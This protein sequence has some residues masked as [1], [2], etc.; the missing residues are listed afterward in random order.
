M[1]GN[2]PTMNL[3]KRKPNNMGWDYIGAAWPR[4][5]KEGYSVT[6]ELTR[7]G[8]KIKCLLVPATEKA[9]NNSKREESEPRQ[10][11]EVIDDS[12]PF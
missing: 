12:L 2:K 4:E 5:G 1:N 8:E 6:I 9:T 10:I 3:I 11:G 7:G